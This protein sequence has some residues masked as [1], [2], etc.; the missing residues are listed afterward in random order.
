MEEIISTLLTKISTFF[1]FLRREEIRE[2]AQN[3]CTIHKIAT[4]SSTISEFATKS[5]TICKLAAKTSTIR[6]TV[7]INVT[8]SG[9]C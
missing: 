2:F 3:N 9:T 1:G 8:S 6:V 7:L 5:S 4:K